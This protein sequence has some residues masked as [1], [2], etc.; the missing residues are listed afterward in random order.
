MNAA[1]KVRSMSI[2]RALEWAFRDECARLEFD[3]MGDTSGSLRQGLD[4]VWLLMQR[5]RLG[6]KID[7]GGASEPASDAQIIASIVARLPI[8]HGGRPMAVT[9]AELARGGMVPDWMRDAVPRYH[10]DD[11]TQNQYGWM[12]KVEDSDRLGLRGWRPV[13]RR[14]RKG[15]IRKEPVLYCPV[16]VSPTVAQ[17]ARAR[18]HYLQWWGALLWLRSELTQYFDLTDAMPPLTPWRPS[19][20][21]TPKATLA[22]ETTPLSLSR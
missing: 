9:I 21:T 16:H 14:G 11:V 8:E 3:E 22:R 19:T 2:Q 4:T 18:R 1:A 13:E 20:K 7:G 12:A 5:G 17:I 10:P 15:R 6:C